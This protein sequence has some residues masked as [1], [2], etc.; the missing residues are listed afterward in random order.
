MTWLFLCVEE[1]SGKVSARFTDRPLSAMETAIYWVEYV[2]RHGNKPLRSPALDLAWWQIALL[3]VYAVTIFVIVS[4]IAI[5]TAIIRSLL[6]AV[7]T[8]HLPQAKKIN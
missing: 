7:T 4:I 6:R 3:D 5:I 1:T 8:T 2:I